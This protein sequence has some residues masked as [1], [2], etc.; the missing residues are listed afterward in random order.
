MPLVPA[1]SET[2]PHLPPQTEDLL[3]QIGE[4]GESLSLPTYIVGGF[5]RDWLHTTL[6]GELGGDIPEGRSLDFDIV[7]EGDAHQLAQHIH[8]LLGGRLTLHRS[9][10]TASLRLKTT[11]IDFT[12]AR[13]ET[14]P[15][16]AALP[17][18]F[19]STL[20]DDLFRRDFTINAMAVRINPTFFGSLID[21][22]DGKPDLEHG[23]IRILHENSFIDDPTRVFRAIRFEQRLGFRLE[24]QT[25][26]LLKQAVGERL[27]LRLSPARIRE[28][29]RLLFS[30]ADPVSP[31]LR[32]NELGIFTCLHHQLNLTEEGKAV[33]RRTPSVLSMPKV[34]LSLQHLS[35]RWL[36]F[37]LPFALAMAPEQ[38]QEPADLLR[39][40]RA[41]A[42]LLLEVVQKAKP[43]LDT[44]AALTDPTPS[45]VWEIVSPLHPLTLIHLLARC[46]PGRPEHALLSAYLT[47]YRYVPL[48]IDGNDLQE[49]GFAPGPALGETLR[50]TLK[51]KLDGLVSGK[52]QELSFAKRYLH[53]L[54]DSS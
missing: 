16:P 4:A 49:A 51:A 40:R 35:L 42:E 15:H 1:H 21:F 5:V 3:R 32:A 54:N 38:A 11:R 9:F 20:K 41:E 36:L 52:S 50:Q 30:E 28:Q 46:Q 22:F 45:Q 25:E 48:E 18:V 47:I 7:V 34:T 26:R 29:L 14:Y 27:I 12:S 33:L 39:L 19:F 17:R 37:F 10:G 24:P 53:S 13:G 31:A 8:P 44:L 23:L 2:L 43:T 6:S